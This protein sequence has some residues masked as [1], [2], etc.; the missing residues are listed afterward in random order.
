MNHQVR[1]SP[2]SISFSLSL[3]ASVSGEYP[4]VMVCLAKSISPLPSNNEAGGIIKS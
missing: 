4:I 2:P 3:L 1:N